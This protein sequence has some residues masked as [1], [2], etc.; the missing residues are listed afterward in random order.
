MREPND[1]DI[2]IE[3][4]NA[5]AAAVE[6]LTADH[7]DEILKA[8]AIAGRAKRAEHETVDDASARKI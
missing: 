4:R 7:E 2:P 6:G 1:D 3:Q 5:M 8:L